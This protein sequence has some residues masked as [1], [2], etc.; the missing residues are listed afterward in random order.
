MCSVLWVCLCKQECKYGGTHA[1]LRL[2][3]LQ[4]NACIYVCMYIDIKIYKYLY[5]VKIPH[6]AALTNLGFFKVEAPNQKPSQ[7]GVR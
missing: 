5:N 4:A 1:Y 7:M 2:A 3:I 6:V